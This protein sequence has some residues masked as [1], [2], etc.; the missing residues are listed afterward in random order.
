MNKIEIYYHNTTYGELIL[1]SYENKLCLCDWRYRKMRSS[2]DNRVKSLL[3]GEFIERDNDL[4]K[5]VRTQLEE[6]FKGERKEFDIPLLFVGSEFQKRVWSGLLDIKYGETVSYIKLAENLGDRKAVR[7]V[8][9]ANGANGISIFVP[10]HRVIGSDGKL[11]GYA[12]GLRTK[13]KLLSLE[14]NEIQSKLF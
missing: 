10:C 8:A 11:T 7:A 14:Q 6:Y 9:N 1:G 3:N 4:F 5:E 13:E 12:G 2:I